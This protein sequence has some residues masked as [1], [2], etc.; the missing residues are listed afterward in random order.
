MHIYIN[1][2]TKSK[3]I[4]QV[5]LMVSTVF[6]YVMALDNKNFFLCLQDENNS[7]RLF[8]V[9][10]SGLET[11]KNFSHKQRSHFAVDGLN[12]LACLMTFHL[13]LK[14]VP[15]SFKLQ[16]YLLSSVDCCLLECLKDVL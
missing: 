5:L 12:G 7:L 14:L 4:I 8:N 15:F 11:M 10:I 9:L 6:G 13:M 16:I 2:C 1:S 3:G